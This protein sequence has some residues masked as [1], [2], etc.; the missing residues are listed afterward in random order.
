M[1]RKLTQKQRDRKWKRWRQA[2]IDC[3]PNESERK[4]MR[5]K[6]NIPTPEGW[7]DLEAMKRAKRRL[8]GGE[9]RRRWHYLVAGVEA[10]R[11]R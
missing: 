11:T 2:Q 7:P 10:A 5:A 4:R 3:M 1:R 6:L 9:T 8:R